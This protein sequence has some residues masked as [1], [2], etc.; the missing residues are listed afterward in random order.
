MKMKETKYKK[1][2]FHFLNETV[3][4]KKH[5]DKLRQWLNVILSGV[6]VGL[7]AC[8]VFSYVIWNVQQKNA[9]LEADSVGAETVQNEQ[10]VWNMD[11]KQWMNDAK[12]NFVKIQNPSDEEDAKAG[13]IYRMDNQYIYIV[14]EIFEQNDE[15]F[16]IIYDENEITQ[17]KPSQVDNKLGINLW[18]LNVR[19]VDSSMYNAVSEVVISKTADCEQNDA[20]MVVTLDGS[21]NICQLLGTL[22]SVTATVT[23]EDGIYDMCATDVSNIYN[24]SAFVINESGELVGMSIQNMNGD[25]FNNHMTVVKI[26]SVKKE[27][28]HLVEDKARAALGVEGVSV[29]QSDMVRYGDNVTYGVWLSKVTEGSAAYEGGI[30]SGDIITYIDD[31]VVLDLPT[32]KDLLLD[33]KAGDVVTIRFLREYKNGYKECSVKVTLE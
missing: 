5:R 26:Q 20:V 1:E 7:I 9:E 14:S 22:T 3:N 31:Y 21:N 32:M 19:D 24:K 4:E 8:G 17:A 12:K 28:E 27:I 6:L 30:M 29:S 13:M 25:K 33:Y 11:I 10:S 18:K 15:A 2:E 23:M 16:Q